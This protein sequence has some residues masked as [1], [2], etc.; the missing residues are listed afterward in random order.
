MAIEQNKTDAKEQNFK[1]L[2][3]Y[4]LGT[5]RFIPKKELVTKFGISMASKAYANDLADVELRNI[6]D[7]IYD[8]ALSNMPSH[9]ALI[10]YAKL[11]ENANNEQECLARAFGYMAQYVINGGDASSHRSGI[12][13]TN[14]TYIDPAIMEKLT[15]GI[16][17]KRLLMNGL[18]GAGSEVL[19]KGEYCFNVEDVTSLVFG[20]DY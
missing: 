3:V 9:N 8:Y 12:N 17:V 10:M 7:S 16:Q 6:S 19:Y 5:H 1:D 14:G 2:M 4:N 20:V 18:Q 11:A 15:I 13:F